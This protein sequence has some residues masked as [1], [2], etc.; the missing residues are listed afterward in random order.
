MAFTTNI[1]GVAQVDDSI[2]LAYDTQFLL[3]AGQEN[4]M[5][6]LVQYK[7]QIGAK[8]IQFPKY[9]LLSLATTPLTEGDDVV[10]EA[11]ADAP[12][13][14]T[15]AE[16]GRVVT[17]TSLASLQTGG[18]IDLAAAALVG[19]NL[20]QTKNKLATLALDA[21]TNVI[22][23]GGV[24]LASLAGTDI[25]T[26]AVLNQAYNKLSRK[27]VG[28]INGEYVLVAHDDVIADLRADTS[29]GGW[30]DVTKY[31]APGETLANEV[32]MFKGFRVVRNNQATY[33]DQTGAGTVD[34]Y[35]SYVIGFNALGLAESFAPE[36]RATGPFD[37]LGR[38]VNLGWYGVFN[39]GIVDTDAVWKIQ[40]ASSLGANAS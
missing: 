4:V 6:Q 1:S 25:L 26:G 19:K 40:T 32:G 12:I 11:L 31:A 18:T 3:E 22:T 28:R 15:P 39:Y 27:N 33:A 23:P 21:S 34:V 29:A 8:S 13:L 5:D 38:L 30:V 9:S 36:M 7:A 17:P 14:I 2:K 16:Y 20:A 24:A 37:K 35:N 10:S